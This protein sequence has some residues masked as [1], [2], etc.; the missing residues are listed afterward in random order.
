MWKYFCGLCVLFLLSCTST[1]KEKTLSITE[2]TASRPDSFASDSVMLDYI[3][4]VHFNYMWDGAE[5]T[6][7]LAP[8]RI[9]LDGNYPQNDSSV[10]TTGGSGFG[11]AGILVAIDRKFISREEGVARLHK[12]VDYLTRAD[13]FHGVWPHWLDGPTGKVKPF[14]TKDDGAIWWKAVLLCKAYFV[15][16]S[17]SKMEI[18]KSSSCVQRLINCG[19]KWSS[20]GIRMVRM[21]SIGI[22]RPIMAGK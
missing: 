14:G 19:M 16:A 6:S 8:E 11:I 15:S 10:V 13:R 18:R 3:Q 20:T 17:I 1:S 21:S 5:K 7:G 12:I 2:Q 22:G 9:H 4:K